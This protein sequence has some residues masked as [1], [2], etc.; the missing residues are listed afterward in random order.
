MKKKLAA[1]TLALAIGS[2][3]FI[4]AE[5]SA[6]SSGNSLGNQLLSKNT[7]PFT[8]RPATIVGQVLEITVP[9]G[10]TLLTLQPG[11]VLYLAGDSTLHKYEMGAKSLQGS[12]LLEASS[13]SLKAEGGLLK[14]LKA[15]EVKSMELDVPVT[16]LKSKED[17]LD[18]N[19]YKSLLASD[20]PVIKFVLKSETLAEGKDADSY[21]MTAKGVLTVA[22]ADQPITL[23]ADAQVTGNQVR[24]KGFQKLK[25]TDYKITP[26]KINLLIASIVCM[27][28]I[29]IHYDVIFAPSAKE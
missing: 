14:A 18:K 13:A 8:E 6:S 1:F 25:M 4:W 28:E 24:L 3:G 20:N 17:G 29:E 2:A 5:P 12:A 22:G 23:K 26:P 7:L 9:T 10:A 21:V 27:D 16:F 15:G 11:S 19:A